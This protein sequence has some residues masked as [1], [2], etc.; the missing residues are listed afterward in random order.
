MAEVSIV[1]DGVAHGAV[2]TYRSSVAATFLVAK[3]EVGCDGVVLVA[4]GIEHNEHGQNLA[5]QLGSVVAERET[6]TVSFVGIDFGDC[7]F[8]GFEAFPAVV[9]ERLCFVKDGL[10]STRGGE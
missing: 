6:Y 2:L 9:G 7:E 4:I 5:N 8:H 1:V 3:L 10:C